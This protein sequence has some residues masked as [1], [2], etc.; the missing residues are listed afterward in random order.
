MDRGERERGE[1]ERKRVCVG[2][3]ERDPG[4]KIKMMSTN[5]PP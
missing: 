4:V 5:V 3:R 1:R 2:G